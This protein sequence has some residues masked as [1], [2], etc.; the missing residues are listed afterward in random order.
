MTGLGAVLVLGW[1]TAAW[2]DSEAARQ[3]AQRKALLAKGRE[4]K[5]DQG[6]PASCGHDKKGEE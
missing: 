4:G 3:F 1:A 5:K 2:A 6:K